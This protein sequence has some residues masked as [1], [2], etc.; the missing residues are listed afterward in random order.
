[1]SHKLTFKLTQHTPL[2]HFQWE[3]QGATLRATEVKP[4]LDRF[5]RVKL[6]SINATLYGTYRSL[7]Q[8][9]PDPREETKKVSPYKLWISEDTTGKKEKFLVGSYISKGVASRYSQE[10]SILSPAPYFADNSSIKN[11]ELEKAKIGLMNDR[12][13]ELTFKFFNPNWEKLLKEAL[14]LF[15]CCTN[16]GTRQSKGFGS[17]SEAGQELRSFESALCGCFINPIYKYIGRTPNDQRSIF[18]TID[19]V[20]KRIKSGDRNSESELRKFYNNQF[21][22]IEWEKPDV[23]AIVANLSKRNIRIDKNTKNTRYIRALLGLAELFEYPKH[24]GVKVQIRHKNKTIERFPSPLLFKV[25]DGQIYLT[26]SPEIN[27]ELDKIS[28]E[29]FEFV[30]VHRGQRQK[31]RLELTTF[32]TGF[33]LSNFL[34]SAIRN[35]MQWEPLPNV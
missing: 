34:Q 24:D 6:K 3:E 19:E 27:A 14:P 26:I 32:P 25:F 33:D 1:M 4:K 8:S 11:G 30:F 13:V 12:G 2:I 5:L 31:D 22:A 35:L 28:D 9:I 29:T 21:P 15:F 16:F 18:K 23:Q 20:Y 10:Y 17:F 7:I